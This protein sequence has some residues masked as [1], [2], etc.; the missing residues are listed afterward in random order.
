MRKIDLIVVHC[1]ATTPDKDLG[2]VEIR[3]MHQAKGWS[4]VGYHFVIRRNG[5]VEKGRDESV[6]GSHVSGYNAT[7]L[8]VCLVGG[9]NKEGRGENNF[10]PE[11][12]ESLKIVLSDLRK[13]YPTARMC[14]HRDLSPDRNKDGRVTPDEWLKECPSFDVGS[15]LSKVGINASPKVG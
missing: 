10:T 15:W 7:S 9:A 14:G 5:R 6:V 3:R 11:Q 12:F 13:R 2:V 4:D 1:A 8:G